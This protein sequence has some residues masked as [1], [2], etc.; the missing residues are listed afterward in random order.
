LSRFV[1]ICEQDAWWRDMAGKY[2]VR[3]EAT[4]SAV[5]AIGE[6]ARQAMH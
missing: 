1:D 3:V 2:D 6:A 4:P 5:P